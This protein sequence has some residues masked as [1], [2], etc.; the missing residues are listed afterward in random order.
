MKPELTYNEAFA[1]LEKLV[2]E[3]EDETI[4]LDVLAEKIHLANEYIRL[5]E[6]KLRTIEAEV[7]Q[8]TAQH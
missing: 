7:Q 3:I 6:S 2:G 1:A 8:A 5:C 4:Q